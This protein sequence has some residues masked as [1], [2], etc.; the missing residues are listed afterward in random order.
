MASS[1]TAGVAANRVLER[2]RRETVTAFGC[3]AYS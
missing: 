2:A 1:V 3:P